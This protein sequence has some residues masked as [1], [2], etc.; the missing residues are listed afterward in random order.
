MG[1]GLVASNTNLKDAILNSVD[2]KGHQPVEPFG[3]HVH[4]RL[5]VFFERSTV[6]PYWI[7]RVAPPDQIRVRRK[8]KDV[9]RLGQSLRIMRQSFSI[10][11]AN[12]PKSK[13]A[14]VASRFF[15]KTALR[16]MLLEKH[17][18][19]RCI[20]CGV[21]RKTKLVKDIAQRRGRRGQLFVQP[22]DHA[23]RSGSATRRLANRRHAWISASSRSG[24]S[25]TICSGLSPFGSRSSAIAHAD[26][27]HASDAGATAALF[28]VYRDPICQGSHCSLLSYPGPRARTA[29]P[30]TIVPTR[31][32]SLNRAT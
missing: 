23:T 1:R 16:T 15:E 3:P 28:G 26:A 9:A 29:R 17:P 10:N 7:I 31:P 6:A 19:R 8:F 11:R 5:P 30:E 24:N 25:S 4:R 14:V 27:A 32:A 20:A 12:L 21:S 13:H 22:D 2:A 18:E